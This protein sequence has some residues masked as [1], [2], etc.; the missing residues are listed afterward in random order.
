MS[1][2]GR[3]MGV[4]YDLRAYVTKLHGHAAWTP[5]QT[6]DEILG[7]V[8][9]QIEHRDTAVRVARK[10]LAASIARL[11]ELTDAEDPA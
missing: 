11:D 6:C 2:P 4:F 9:K 7:R 1:L 10:Q 3:A 8:K 5:C